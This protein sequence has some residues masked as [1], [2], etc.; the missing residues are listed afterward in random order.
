MGGKER[1]LGVSKSSEESEVLAFG[2]F[3]EIFGAKREK[4][5]EEK[6]CETMVEA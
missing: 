4:K 2:T 6:L 1:G 5:K 3:W